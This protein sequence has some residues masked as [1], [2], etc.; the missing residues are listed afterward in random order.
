[1]SFLISFGGPIRGDLFYRLRG[2][3]GTLTADYPY[4]TVETVSWADVGGQQCIQTCVESVPKQ[5]LHVQQYQPSVYHNIFLY[6]QPT[7]FCKTIREPTLKQFHLTTR[8]IT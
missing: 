5:V 4:Q 1:M 3:Y 2:L 6:T 7:Y 8:F